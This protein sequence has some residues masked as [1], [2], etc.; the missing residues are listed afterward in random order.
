[1]ATYQLDG[2]GG[3]GPVAPPAPDTASAGSGVEEVTP[4]HLRVFGN[5]VAALNDAVDTLRAELLSL[6]GAGMSVGS[7]QYAHQIVQYYRNLLGWEA[8]PATAATVGE[9]DKIQQ[10]AIQ[11]AIAWDQS[12]QT[13]AGQFPG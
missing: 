6:S 5:N 13:S 7:G 4:E 8:V 2:G 1:M 9:L 3:G 11:T 12:D 10:A